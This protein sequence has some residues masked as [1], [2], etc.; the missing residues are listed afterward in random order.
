MVDGLAMSDSDDTTCIGDDDSADDDYEP[1]TVDL[2]LQPTV[3]HVTTDGVAAMPPATCVQ[4]V[5][6]GYD[7][8][9]GAY[10]VFVGSTHTLGDVVTALS[11][12]CSVAGV[13]LE[14]QPF[15]LDQDTYYSQ[16]ESVYGERTKLVIGLYGDIELEVPKEF[17]G[18]IYDH[19]FK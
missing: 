4:L 7:D 19:Q 3:A 15:Q 18:H 11:V 17:L 13:L 12:C 6:D 2:W 16:R 10:A 14:Q 5:E 8:V 9:H 1:H